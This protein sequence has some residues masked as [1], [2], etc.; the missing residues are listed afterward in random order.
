V[1]LGEFVHL[2]LAKSRRS[3][4]QF[5]CCA[6][7]VSEGTIAT[8]RDPPIGFGDASAMAFDAVNKHLLIASGVLRLA[9]LYR[10]DEDTEGKRYHP[11]AKIILYLFVLFLTLICPSLHYRLHTTEYFLN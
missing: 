5:L 1:E 10:A 11:S 4:L 2:A 7:G 9:L 3:E 8:T 6:A